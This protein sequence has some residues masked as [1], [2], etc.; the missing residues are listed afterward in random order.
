MQSPPEAA[1]KRN[2]SL[3]WLENLYWLV[4]AALTALQLVYILA[5]NAH[6]RDEELAESV[7]N[8]FW[9]DHRLVYD[10][11]SSN[12]GYYGLLLVVYKLFG[13][14]LHAAKY[15]RLVLYAVAMYSL[16][17]LLQKFMRRFY[18]AVI[19]VTVGL[20][21]TLLFFNTI[22]TGIGI[23]ILYGIVGL[24][25]IIKMKFDGSPKDLSRAF[26]V[27]L[28]AM[29]AAMSYPSFLLYF[30]I[31][32]FLYL[33]QWIRSERKTTKK[34][35]TSAACSALGFII[36]FLVAILYLKNTHDFLNDPVAH[37]GLFRG[38]G[39]LRLDTQ[40]VKNA[41]Y[42][43]LS[44]VFQEG[45]S[46]YYDLE[47]PD[48]SGTLIWIAVAAIFVSGLFIAVKNPSSRPIF[49]L[50]G[51]H[52]VVNLIGSSL[53]EGGGI[54]RSTGLL[55]GIYAWYAITLCGIF[56]QPS[57]R[58]VKWIGALACLLLT[59][60]NLVNYARNIEVVR[61]RSI[62]DDTVWFTA[63]D[64]AEKSL[65]YWLQGTAHGTAITCF[66]ARNRRVACDY[67]KI[68]AAI[69]G[70]RHWNGLPEIPVRAYDWKT[71]EDR[72]LS[73]DLWETYYFPH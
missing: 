21:P 25:I 9:L 34:F 69:A 49:L 11:V 71:R 3:L 7:R 23:D 55:V 68:Y 28:I 66:D 64:T 38:G 15:V 26:L 17:A 18:A 37:A 42:Q 57:L 70:F 30:P 32:A 36:P 48:F 56:T 67:A 44:D 41:A 19:L 51:F 73:I 29:I 47:H 20:S 27:G 52:I 50:A 1:S 54:R 2:E 4:P 14:S 61:G 10:G 72:T 16:A 53:A 22:Q 6:I 24:F 58:K 33:W 45:A 43:T 62:F 8:V 35:V 39:H 31:L 13:F 5:S 46:Y 60:N 63:K 12:V 65:E 40:S 59:A